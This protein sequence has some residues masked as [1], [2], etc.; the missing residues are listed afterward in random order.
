VTRALDEQD[1]KLEILA[2]EVDGLAVA[3]ENVL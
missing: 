3:L 2:R 1:K